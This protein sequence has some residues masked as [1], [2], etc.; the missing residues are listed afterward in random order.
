MKRKLGTALMIFGFVCLLAAGL[1]FGIAEAR[2][3]RAEKA[4]AAA[5]EE[6][7]AQISARTQAREIAAP[8]PAPAAPATSAKPPPT[9]APEVPPEEGAEASPEPPEEEPAA[10]A[11]SADDGAAAEA[12]PEESFTYMGYITIP[13]LNMALPVMSECS[14]YLLQ[15]APCRFSGSV[16]GNNL[17]ISAHNYKRHFRKLLGL[18]EGAELTFTDM[19]G[20]VTAYTVCK[21]EVL[22]P[23]AV[24]DMIVSGYDLTLFTCT[25]GGLTRFTLRCMRAESAAAEAPDGQT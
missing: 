7:L 14:S 23:K 19:E 5:M 11:E 9:A 2:E 15:Y 4:S 20:N 21:T 24:R 6:L 8:T 16:E 25:I 10:P 17:V 12:P 1:L 3:R 18:T 13:S 22:E